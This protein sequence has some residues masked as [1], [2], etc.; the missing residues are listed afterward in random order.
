MNPKSDEPGRARGGGKVARLS[1][2]VL[3]YVRDGAV[4]GV[5]GQNIGRCAVALAHEIVRQ[6]RRGLTLVGCNLSLHADLLIA[7][8][9]VDR[10]ECGTGNLESYGVCHAFRRGVESGTL[11]VDDYDHASML[12]RFVAGGTGLPFMPVRH[13][14]GTSL[15]SGTSRVV[16]KTA[17][18]AN[19]WRPEERVTLVP[20]LRPDVALLHAQ[21]ADLDG[22]VV[23]R[24]PASHDPELARAARA[25]IVTVERLLPRGA[26]DADTPGVVI[27]HHFVSAVVLR[28]YGAWPTGVFGEYPHDDA[29]VRE[30]QTAA[31]EGG[32]RLEDYLRRYVLDPADFDGFLSD[33]RPR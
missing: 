2:A 30:Y 27:T 6:G 19:P 28:P 26:I 31:R 17:A 14:A 32:G 15:N 3:R 16:P 5:G 25:T 1:D 18:V 11:V 7:A 23:L 10:C 29:H 4:V 13:L 20:A 33:A 22:N 9:A 8:G 21:E 24:G 12:A